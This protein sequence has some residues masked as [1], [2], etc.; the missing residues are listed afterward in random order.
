MINKKMPPSK[1]KKPTRKAQE[2]IGEKISKM[3]KEGKRPQ[4]QVI[5]IAFEMARKKGFRSVPTP[6]RKK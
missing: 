5:A 3:M 1:A 2:F 4:S 6:P